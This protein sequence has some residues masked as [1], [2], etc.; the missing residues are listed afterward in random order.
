MTLVKMLNY[1]QREKFLTYGT[2]I[3]ERLESSL[4]VRN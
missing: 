3:K 2:E 4:K 1:F